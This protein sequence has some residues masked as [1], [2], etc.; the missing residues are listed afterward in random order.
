MDQLQQFFDHLEFWHWMSFGVG[1]LVMEML[2]PGVFFLWMGI[3]AG[4][5]GLLMLGLPD[6]DWRIQL[7]VFS[8]LSIICVTGF[9]YWQSKNP[10]ETDNPKLNQRGQQYIGR[11]VSLTK[12]MENGVGQAHV[13]DTVWQVS[14][15][16]AQ[17][18][19]IKQK[20]KVIDIEGATLIIEAYKG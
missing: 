15:L 12:D 4:G 17:S 8:A 9:R 20:L 10:T 5:V 2:L 7:V 11:V 18:F 13:D 19:K 1:L 6:L 3:A 16:D 14:S